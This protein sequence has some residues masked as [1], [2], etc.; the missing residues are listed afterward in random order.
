[1]SDAAGVTITFELRLKPE[2][3]DG[4][5]TAAAAGVLQGTTS[6]PG[7]RS[8]R[9]VQHRDDPGRFLFVEQWDSEQ[10]HRDYMAWRASTGAVE[11][12]KDVAL[13]METNVWP[14]LV[15]EA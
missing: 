12:L 11:G 7:F 8:I 9:I 3:A 10:A 14:D 6:F 5:K 15:V 4:F 2:A 1:M 13:G